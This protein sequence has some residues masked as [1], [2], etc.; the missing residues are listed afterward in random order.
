MGTFKENTQR[1]K[2][3]EGKKDQQ[4]KW[5]QLRKGLQ[6]LLFQIFGHQKNLSSNKK[7]LFLRSKTL[8]RIKLSWSPPFNLLHGRTVVGLMRRGDAIFTIQAL[9]HSHS[10]GS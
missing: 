3:P 10:N 4:Q 9:G 8:A 5:W 6:V 1:E 2:I 7:P